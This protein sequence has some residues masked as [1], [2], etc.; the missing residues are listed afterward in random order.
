M[1]PFNLSV[2]LLTLVFI[3]VCI[4]FIFIQPKFL[5]KEERV[6]EA[7]RKRQDAADEAR[8]KMDEERKK[9]IDFIKAAKESSG[10]LLL[11]VFLLFSDNT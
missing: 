7:L 2:H 1:L 6:A 5:T 8:R 4:L 11:L 3:I 10:F 9:Q